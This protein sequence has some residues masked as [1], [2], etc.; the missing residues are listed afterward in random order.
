MKSFSIIFND[1]SSKE[2][3]ISIKEDENLFEAVIF[4]LKAKG[5][6]IS[7]IVNVLQPIVKNNDS[8]KKY[9]LNK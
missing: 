4:F 3:P 9:K 1:N 2:F 6:E 5:F 8:G 7:E